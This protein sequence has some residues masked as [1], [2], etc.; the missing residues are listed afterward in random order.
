MKCEPAP[1]ILDTQL[2]EDGHGCI[3]L[4]WSF[5]ESPAEAMDIVKHPSI[6]QIHLNK[7]MRRE[8]G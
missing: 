5:T 3:L 7:D 2:G 4:N 8:L 6:T 1:E